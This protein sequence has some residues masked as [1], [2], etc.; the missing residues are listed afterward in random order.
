[1]KPKIVHEFWEFL[2][3]Y[4]VFTLAIAFIM[5]GASNAL[6]NSLVKDI[7]MP[8]VA[9]LMADNWREGTLN[10]GPVH[11]IYGAFLAELLNFL[12]LALI[13]FLVTKKLI[14]IEN[15]QKK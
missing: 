13:I 2:R 12:I 10:I 11:M 7:I 15:E 6:V 9:P 3:E 1:M 4:K 8:I 14:K 5:G